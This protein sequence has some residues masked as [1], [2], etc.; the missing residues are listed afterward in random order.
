M[1]GSQARSKRKFS[2]GRYRDY[3]KKKHFELARTPAH[4]KIGVVRES[5]LSGRGGNR[6]F[7]LLS[8]DTANVYD[9]KQK[10]YFKSK[11]LSV[12]ESKANR[13]FIRRNIMTKGGVVKTELG[14]ARITSRPGQEKA[15]NA[16]LI[17]EK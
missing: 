4:T 9:A 13:H 6:K 12:V 10:K 15:I 5:V 14:N 3:R 16:V 1:A 11:I 8:C 17:G 2:G 7:L